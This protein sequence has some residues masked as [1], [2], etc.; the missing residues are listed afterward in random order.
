MFETLC[1]CIVTEISLTSKGYKIKVLK[2]QT[3]KNTQK[4][5]EH[6]FKHLWNNHLK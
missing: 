6:F 1:G 2:K 4:H 3:K 5:F